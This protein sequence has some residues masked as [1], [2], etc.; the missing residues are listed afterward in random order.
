MN[1]TFQPRRGAKATKMVSFCVVAFR[2]NFFWGL[3][4]RLFGAIDIAITRICRGL[5]CRADPARF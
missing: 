5:G 2:G 3:A 4:E 1:K